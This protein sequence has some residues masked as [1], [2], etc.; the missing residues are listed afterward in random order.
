[1]ARFRLLSGIHNEGGRTYKPGETIDSKTDLN[2]FNVPG[3]VRFEQVGPGRPRKEAE[4][5]TPGQE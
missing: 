1:M 3:S 5:E 4:P 2:R